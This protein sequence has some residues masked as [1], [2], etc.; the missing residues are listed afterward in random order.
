MCYHVLRQILHSDFDIVNRFVSSLLSK[1]VIHRLA[2]QIASTNL[3]MTS[4]NKQ[5]RFP[6]GL[7]QLDE[8]LGSPLINDISLVQKMCIYSCVTLSTTLLMR[9]VQFYA[10]SA[11]DARKVFLGFTGT[12]FSNSEWDSTQNVLMIVLHCSKQISRNCTHLLPNTRSTHTANIFF[13]V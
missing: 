3:E 11:C 1:L 10:R 8:T 13:S 6:A 2:V 5:T 4:C 12:F 9:A 7:L